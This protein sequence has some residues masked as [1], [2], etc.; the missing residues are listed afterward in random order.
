MGLLSYEH[1]EHRTNDWVVVEEAGGDQENV[2]VAKSELKGGLAA[3]DSAECSA[4]VG[5][6]VIEFNQVLSLDEA[7]L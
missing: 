3:A 6:V 7:E 2:A 4:A 5:W 1:V